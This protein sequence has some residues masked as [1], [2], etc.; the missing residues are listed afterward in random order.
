MQPMAGETV[1]DN[2]NPMGRIFTSATTFF[3][4]PAAQA[5]PGGYALGSQAS[6]ATVTQITSEAG[7]NRF[8]RG[9]ESPFN[10]DFEVIP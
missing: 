7:F 2:A 8:R 9:A 10:R 1:E 6:E 4:T 3:C 5:Q